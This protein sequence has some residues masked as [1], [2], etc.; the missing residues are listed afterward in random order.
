ML[1]CSVPVPMSLKIQFWGGW[2]SKSTPPSSKVLEN[3]GV[4]CREHAFVAISRPQI[5]RWPQQNAVVFPR[6][7]SSTS[8]RIRF[9]EADLNF[10][11][12][13]PSELNFPKQPYSTPP[14]RSMCT[15]GRSKTY[16]TSTE[17]SARSSATAA[18]A[19]RKTSSRSSCGAKRESGG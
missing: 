2:V 12:Y 13:L 15:T 5:I 3:R 14:T 11:G 19:N 17:F 4:A 6:P 18:L 8:S 9:F 1:L 10:E 16:R 7:T